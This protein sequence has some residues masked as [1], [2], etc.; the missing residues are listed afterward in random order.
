VKNPT[1]SAV[2]ACFIQC[3]CSAL[4]KIRFINKQ[5]SIETNHQKRAGRRGER[6]R[7]GKRVGE[8]KRERWRERLQ[9]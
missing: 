9:D 2:F 3:Y 4:D 7:E 8:T 5:Y 6:V 1:H